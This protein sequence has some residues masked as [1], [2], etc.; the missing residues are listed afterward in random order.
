MLVLATLCQAIGADIASGQDLLPAA[1]HAALEPYGMEVLARSED[2]SAAIFESWREAGFTDGELL[3]NDTLAPVVFRAL[4]GE[5]NRSQDGTKAMACLEALRRSVDNGRADLSK[6]EDLA[7]AYWRGWFRWSIRLGAWDRYRE[8]WHAYR[9]SRS[10]S[11]DGRV[12]NAG[13]D[14]ARRLI[15]ESAAEREALNLDHRVGLARLRQQVDD[16]WTMPGDMVRYLFRDEGNPLPLVDLIEQGHPGWPPWTRAWAP[17]RRAAHDGDWPTAAAMVDR[18][19]A[20]QD[21][22]P[23]MQVALGRFR[24]T[25]RTRSSGT[26]PGSMDTGRGWPGI[27]YGRGAW[28]LH[29]LRIRQDA[30]RSLHATVRAWDDLPADLALRV[31]LVTPEGRKVFAVTVRLADVTEACN[32]GLPPYGLD[33]PIAI[34]IPG[35]VSADAW[36]LMEFRHEGDT[37]RIKRDDGLARV[38]WERWHD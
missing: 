32:A 14:I 36:C 6:D 34:S 27:A 12:A 15:L 33:I 17:A 5:A 4:Y 28:S 35:F 16:R 10:R 30:P 23:R 20:D 24:E 18:L 38:E 3:A 25:C 8:Q 21:V 1:M 11:L 29:D 22:S 9:E 2:Y 19:M 26:A 37:R 13:S 7:A 31:Q